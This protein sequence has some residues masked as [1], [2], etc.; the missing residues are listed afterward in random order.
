MLLFLVEHRVQPQY[1]IH[2]YQ[3]ICH[4]STAYQYTHPYAI[5]LKLWLILSKIYLDFFVDRTEFSNKIFEL[6][7]SWRRPISFRNQSI[8]LRY[9][10]ETS[11]LICSANQWTGF[12]MISASVMK[13][14]TYFFP[15]SP[16]DAPENIRKPKNQIV[17]K[18]LKGNTGKN[19]VRDNS[20]SKFQNFPKHFL[21]PD[22]H[23]YVCLSGGRKY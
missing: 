4:R 21:P 8:D 10:I 1:Q 20:F 19:Y 2:Q 22:T 3:M 13:G 14:L 5:L 15:V 6:T 11:P 23:T 12:Y 17:S 16:F 18:E 9:H 7:L